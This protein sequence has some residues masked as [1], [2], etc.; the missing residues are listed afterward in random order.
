MSSFS[1]TVI[2][3][4]ISWSPKAT[5]A[6]RH[7]EFIVIIA[8]FKKV[9]VCANC[10]DFLAYTFGAARSVP[11]LITKKYDGA[12]IKD[13]KNHQKEADK[14]ITSEGMLKAALSSEKGQHRIADRMAGLQTYAFSDK[15][16]TDVEFGE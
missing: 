3:L 11:N 8:N 12:A 4:N 10:I 5:H 1:S 15:N 14:T 13:Y 9:L 6:I 7:N 2:L 16:N